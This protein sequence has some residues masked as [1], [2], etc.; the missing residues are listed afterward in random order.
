MRTK[1]TLVLLLLN[2]V[3]F[4][5]IVQARHRWRVEADTAERDRHPLRE[6]AVNLQGIT[7]GAPGTTAVTLEKR[8]GKTW[9]MTAPLDWLANETAVT[10]ITGL[11]QNLVAKVTLPVAGLAANGQSL[12][13]YGLEKPEL[14][15]TLVPTPADPA[16]VP[17]PAVV[18]VGSKLKG[19][20]RYLLSPDGTRVHVIDEAFV[21]RLV[22]AIRGSPDS[23]VFTIAPFEAGALSLENAGATDRIRREDDRWNLETLGTRADKAATES[24]LAALAALRLADF[25]TAEQLPADTGLTPAAAFRITI[26]G[27]NRHETLLLGK[28][29]PG[30]KAPEGRTARF[31]KLE[32]RAPVI[33]VD[34]P[35]VLRDEILGRAQERLRDP[36]LLYFD[37]AALASV[38]LTTPGQPA[39][40]LQRLDSALAAN[41]V[42]VEATWQIVVRGEGTPAADR[43]LTADRVLVANLLTNL[44]VL[45]AIRFVN[46]VPSDAEKERYGLKRPDREITL[47]FNGVGKVAPAKPVTLALALGADGGTYAAVVGQ[48]FVYALP[49]DTLARFPID[50]RRYRERLVAPALP[51]GAQITAL[52]L[53]PATGGEPRFSGTLDE[54]K[55]TWPLVIAAEPS[56]RRREALQRLLV[57]DK[58]RPALL[59]AVRAD[60]FVEDAFS[61]TVLVN[62]ALRPWAWQLT[63]T[64]TLPGAAA[65][66]TRTYLLAD[67]AGAE[68]QAGSPKGEADT[69]FTLE[70]ALMDALWA[71]TYD[72]DPGAPPSATP[73]SAPTAP[74]APAT[75]GP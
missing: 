34:F 74:P 52:A 1:V 7:V 22:A 54:N 63:L 11:V 24:A 72:S 48:P 57:G 43:T 59:R 13:D 20:N 15:L 12:A 9:H 61:P 14:T 28:P 42:P 62:G 18:K 66:A 44:E 39:L 60:K 46:D 32:H 53:A 67:R 3:L 75:A 19:D 45:K 36:R 56:A 51:E 35:D 68:Q 29:V 38:T 65:P 5:W 41:S 64:Y 55:K 2:V 23:R 71:L 40:V 33:Q 16:T 47:A 73:V 69:V 37:R 49:R 17:T 27:N 31:A 4:A 25:P 8:A 58:D 10:T 26:E 50:A 6:L 70:P 21:T 30:A